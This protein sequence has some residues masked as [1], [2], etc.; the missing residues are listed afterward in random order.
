MPA[1]RWNPLET[2]RGRRLLF[3]LLYLSEGA[4]IG[5]IWWH[6]PTRL[7][8]ADVPIERITA[9]TAM[10]VLPWT[11]K[12]LWAPLID[13]VRGARWTFRHWI[14]AAQVVM[15]LAL[16]P[17]FWLD[18][19]ADFPLFSALLLVHAFAASTQDVAIDAL[20]IATTRPGERGGINGWM[21][22]GMLLG[23]S[24][25][26]GVALVVDQWVGSGVVIAALI[27]TIWASLGVVSFARET[28]AMI[29]RES[30]GFARTLVGGVA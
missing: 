19:Q 8:A 24:L 18:L 25:F 14:I 11:F 21:Q 6:L 16:V 26:G 1:G 17:L 13:T 22:A 15:G 4:P 30:A 23:R 3:A 7:R 29:E 20:A 5:Y 27:G 28:P 12:F 10:L 2:Q 9:L